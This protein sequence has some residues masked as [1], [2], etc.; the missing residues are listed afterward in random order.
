MCLIVQAKDEAPI[1]FGKKIKEDDAPSLFTKAKG[2][3]L[4]AEIHPKPLRAPGRLGK[5][6]RRDR[7][8][9]KIFAAPSPVGLASLRARTHIARV[10]EYVLARAEGGFTS[11]STSEFSPV[12]FVPNTF[13]GDKHKQGTN[14]TEG[15]CLAV[16]VWFGCRSVHAL[17]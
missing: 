17:V 6:G 12:R 13:L 5:Q 3:S 2:D 1:L 9:R 4:F 11:E 15:G 14:R 8:R 16:R 7:P 10:C